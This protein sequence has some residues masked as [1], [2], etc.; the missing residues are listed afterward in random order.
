MHEV[1]P[2]LST[3]MSSFLGFTGKQLAYLS[4]ETPGG[5]LKAAAE[6]EDLSKRL[7]HH[8]VSL[9]TIPLYMYSLLMPFQSVTVVTK[10]SIMRA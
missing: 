10:L 3:K 7:L 5:A 2:L 1:A 9:P 6:Q 8:C 4:L